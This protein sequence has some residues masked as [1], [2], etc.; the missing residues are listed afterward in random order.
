MRAPPEWLLLCE[1]LLDG[2]ALDW[3]GACCGACSR[4]AGQLGPALIDFVPPACSPRG[5][6]G[7][8]LSCDSGEWERTDAGVGAGVDSF[9]EYL[10][11]ARRLCWAQGKAAL[12]LHPV[13]WHC[14][15]AL[16]GLLG[17]PEFAAGQQGPGQ[18]VA[19]RLSSV[20]PDAP[21]CLQAYLAFGDERYLHMFKEVYAAAM[22][23]LQLDP[24][25]HGTIW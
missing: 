12:L 16:G 8:T 18:S 24:A 21:A 6:V 4:C 10:L 2:S 23:N 3:H 25:F 13:P 11:K 7:N 19:R 1:H 20:M 14:C 9:Y 17:M 5:L 15:R 22:I